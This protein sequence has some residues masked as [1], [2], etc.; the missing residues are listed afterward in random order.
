MLDLYDHSLQFVLRHRASTVAF[1]LVV[2]V[3]T[4]LLFVRIPK[5]FISD[6]DNDQLLIRPKPSRSFFRPDEPLPAAGGSHR[7]PG[8]IDNRLLFGSKRFKPAIGGPNLAACSCTSARAERDS[9]DT[10]IGRLRQKL[11][12]LLT[13]GCTSETRRRS[14]SA[15]RSRRRFINTHCKVP[16]R[17]TLCRSRKAGRQ[18]GT[19][20]GVTDV[21]SDLQLQSPQLNVEIDRDKAAALKVSA[22]QIENA[23]FDAYGPRWFSTIYAPT[24]QYQEMLDLQSEYQSRPDAFHCSTESTMA[25]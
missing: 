18:T 8:S 13:C 17:R 16:I 21:I 15:A 5:G 3:A 1:S 10:I 23:L 9:L 6:S 14:E 7:S 20:A 25:C 24:N 2:L 12:G 4:G 11:S 22:Q 19:I